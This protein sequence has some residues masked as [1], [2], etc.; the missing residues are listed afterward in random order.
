MPVIPHDAERDHPHAEQIH[1]FR[2]NV[3]KCTI[4]AGFVEDDLLAIPA[5]DDMMDAPRTALST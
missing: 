5:V 4:I 3:E 2:Q 1:R